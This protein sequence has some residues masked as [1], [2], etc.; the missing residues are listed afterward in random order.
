[1]N[2]HKRVVKETLN[3]LYARITG[4][5]ASDRER[6]RIALV[7]LEQ[8]APTAP[9]FDMNGATVAQ[10]QT[11]VEGKAITAVDALKHEYENANRK[12]LINWLLERDA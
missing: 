7:A 2:Q 12:T 11:A 1:M 5:L 6:H 3:F 9:T 4:P 10:V 8:L